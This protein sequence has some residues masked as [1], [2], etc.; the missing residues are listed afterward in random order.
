MRRVAELG[1]LGAVKRIP[2]TCRSA[3]ALVCLC[4]CCTDIEH[5]S[6]S[7]AIAPVVATGRTTESP[8]P[9]AALCVRPSGMCTQAIHGLHCAILPPD[10]LQ[11]GQQIEWTTISPSIDQSLIL[12]RMLE[13][14]KGWWLLNPEPL[15]DG[16]VNTTPLL[17]RIKDN[18]I[19]QRVPAPLWSP[20]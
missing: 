3:L 12:R 15:I 9:P 1:S 5:R 2:F 13:S 7:I 11:P 4:G 10:M 6:K 18:P 19:D 20:L 17:I 14:K 8:V 16:G